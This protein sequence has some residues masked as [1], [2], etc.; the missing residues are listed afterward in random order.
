MSADPTVLIGALVAGFLSWATQRTPALIAALPLVAYALVV[1]HDAIS[2]HR[3][4][5]HR[6]RTGRR[7]KR[8]PALT[9]T[10]MDR[11]HGTGYPHP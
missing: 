8:P 1:G 9:Q 5:R 4:R 2:D 3:A 7:G 11:H 6:A 10:T